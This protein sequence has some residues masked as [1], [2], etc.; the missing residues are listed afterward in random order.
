MFL[1]KN[2][3]KNIQSIYS[4]T[5]ECNYKIGGLKNELPINQKGI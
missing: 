5:K 3:R 4:V 2:D 1:T